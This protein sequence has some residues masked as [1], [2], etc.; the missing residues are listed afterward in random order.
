[1]DKNL[2]CTVPK[3]EDFCPLKTVFEIKHVDSRRPSLK[4]KNLRLW[5]PRMAD[6][7]SWK[8]KKQNS[9]PLKNKICR[10]RWAAVFIQKCIVVNGSA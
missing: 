9:S 8:D 5:V 4:D 2:P 6:F 3:G 10:V 1:M 7:M